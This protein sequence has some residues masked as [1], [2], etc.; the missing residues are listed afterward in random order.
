MF[1][2]CLEKQF[3]WKS[4]HVDKFRLRKTIYFEKPTKTKTKQN[5]KNKN[6]KQ[7]KQAGEYA[8]QSNHK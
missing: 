2:F 6:K 8:Y 4:F 7:T 3:G 1:T 5:K